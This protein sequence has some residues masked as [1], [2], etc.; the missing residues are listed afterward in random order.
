[1]DI[2]MIDPVKEA[3]INV[4][5]TMAMINPE[6]GEPFVKSGK[7]AKG[8]IS[9]IIGLAGQKKGVIIISFTSAAICKIV[10]S[11]LGTEYTTIDR[12]VSDA[13]GELANMISGDARRRF[14]EMGRVFE[15]GLPT[16][17]HGP[18][19]EIESVTGG[20]VYAIPFKVEGHEFEVEVSFDE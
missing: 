9:G 6:P 7:K 18:G 12:D 14:N 1:M 19:H 17:I 15:A 13:V 10:G 2:N 3:A 4:I 11:M 5:S 16:V 20:P 8:D